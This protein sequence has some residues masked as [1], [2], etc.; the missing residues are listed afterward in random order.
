MGKVEHR[1]FDFLVSCEGEHETWGFLPFNLYAHS[2]MLHAP[3][4]S[5][6]ILYL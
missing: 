6:F 5:S 3:N 1:A 2:C 4:P